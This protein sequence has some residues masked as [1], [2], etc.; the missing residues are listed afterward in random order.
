MKFKDFLAKL[1]EGLVQYTPEYTSGYAAHKAG[2]SN[3]NPHKVGTDK[4]KQWNAGY[5]H[6][7][8]VATALINHGPKENESIE[9]NEAI[10]GHAAV[11]MAHTGGGMHHD[12]ELHARAV[13][14]ISHA[15]R[16]EGPKLSI[17][18]LKHHLDNELLGLKSSHPDAL[19]NLH[20]NLMKVK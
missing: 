5:R 11:L 16:H 7:L 15:L 18:R 2:K 14:R 13:T 17:D 10:D 6:S 3:V 20:A 1:D 4:H 19:K 12:K 9:V 8:S